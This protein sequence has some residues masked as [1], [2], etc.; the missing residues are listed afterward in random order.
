MM[1]TSKCIARLLR[2]QVHLWLGFE[3]V[4]AYV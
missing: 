3:T 2:E 1:T 4:E